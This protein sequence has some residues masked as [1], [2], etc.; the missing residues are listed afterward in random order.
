MRARI[1]ANLVDQRAHAMTMQGL[2]E[3]FLRVGV[4]QYILAQSRKRPHGLE[5][6]DQITGFTRVAL[7][8]TIDDRSRGRSNANRRF[9][10]QA[11]IAVVAGEYGDPVGY[12]FHRHTVETEFLARPSLD[13]EDMLAG[14][15]RV[16]PEVRT[17]TVVL[18]ALPATQGD[19]IGLAR[20]GA[21]HQVVGPGRG[22]I[23]G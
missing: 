19:A 11:Q 6:F 5:Q 2:S 7:P 14:S 21:C 23:G 15:E 1:A 12:P 9:Q 22:R 10:A 18:T 20:G 17:R 13:L 8:P 4:N 16:F 3:K